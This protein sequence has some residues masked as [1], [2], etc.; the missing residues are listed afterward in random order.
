MKRKYWWI[1][2]VIQLAGTLA[3]AEAVFL[4]FPTLWLLSLLL[5]LPGSLA[6][7][8]EFEPSHLGTDLP[9]WTL[10]SIAVTINVFLFTVASFLLRRHRKRN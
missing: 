6:S 8:P 4:Q 3:T 2:G 1:F 9:L 5:L 7:L 10:C